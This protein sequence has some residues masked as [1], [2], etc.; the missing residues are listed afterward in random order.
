MFLCILNHL[1]CWRVMIDCASTSQE[2]KIRFTLRMYYFYLHS[3][4]D[5]II[6]IFERRHWTE[7]YSIVW[8]SSIFDGSSYRSL[9]FFFFFFT[10]ISIWHRMRQFFLHR[11][12]QLHYLHA[13][14][15]SVTL[16][17]WCVDPWKPRKDGTSAKKFNISRENVP[18]YTNTCI[19]YI[20]I[21]L[22]FLWKVMFFS[23][24]F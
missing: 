9:T 23:L 5:E 20:N 8:M 3:N 7:K 19:G 11:T 22:H 4:C 15:D 16:N 6:M 14:L 18:K 2:I 10:G 13:R 21:L 24:K 12:L 17:Q 1:Q